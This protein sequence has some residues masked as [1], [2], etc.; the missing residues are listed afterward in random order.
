MKLRTRNRSERLHFG[1]RLES[2]DLLTSWGLDSIDASDVWE[3]GYQGQGVVVA[4][5]DSGIAVHLDLIPNIWVNSKEPLNGLDDDGNGYVDDANGWNF[6]DQSNNPIGTND[7]GTHV[8][9]TIAAVNNQLGSTGVAYR[10]KFM[11][12]RVFDDGGVALTSDIADAVR[13]AVDNGADIINLSVGSTATRSMSLALEYAAQENV[14][15][16]AAS[17]NDDANQPLYPAS[18][19]ATLDNVISVGAHDRNFVS[20]HSSNRVGSS[21]AVQVDAPGVGIESTISDNGYALLGGTSSAAAHVAGIAALVLSADRSLTASELR[22]AL[23][24]SARAQKVFGSDSVGAVNARRAVASVVGSVAAASV[25]VVTTNLVEAD[26]DDS[27]T[28]DFNDFLVLAQNFGNVGITHQ[29]GDT[30]GDGRV[31]FSDFLTLAQSYGTNISGDSRRERVPFLTAIGFA[32]SSVSAVEVSAP[33]SDTDSNEAASS[34]EVL[35]DE[36]SEA[37]VQIAVPLPASDSNETEQSSSEPAPVEQAPSQQPNGNDELDPSEPLG[38]TNE[39][40]L[41]DMVPND[42]DSTPAQEAVDAALEELAEE[43]TWNAGAIL[44]SLFSSF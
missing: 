19:S 36:L 20:T 43:K 38:S 44:A 31:L 6:V 16:V 21:Q 9:G 1:E 33:E 15:V 28:I 34:N 22:D 13:Y 30:N 17:G 25:P 2:K 26:F 42:Q 23:V 14:L 18:S 32:Q 35:E 41:A 12:L 29:G 10:S 27:G 5:I 40:Q 24:D 8:A 37:I 11:P 7:H 39:E 3:Q 4:V